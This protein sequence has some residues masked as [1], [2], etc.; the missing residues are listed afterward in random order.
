[1]SHKNCNRVNQYAVSHN[2]LRND[3]NRAD[4][5]D[6]SHTIFQ[7]RTAIELILTVVC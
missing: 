2:L 7:E 4:P 1:M 3:C 6:V 5:F